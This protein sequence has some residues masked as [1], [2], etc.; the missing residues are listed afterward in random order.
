M[1]GRVNSGAV[2]AR[3]RPIARSGSVPGL[4]VRPHT[5]R[6][7]TKPGQ[8]ARKSDPVSRFHQYNNAWKRNKFL[9]K[10]RR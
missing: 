10:T 3:S 6:R 4:S 9:A 1:G 2:S 5:A 7:R 8:L